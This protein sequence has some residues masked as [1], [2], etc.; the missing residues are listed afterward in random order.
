[1]R[2]RALKAPY[3]PGRRNVTHPQISGKSSKSK[4]VFFK[5]SEMKDLTPI[6]GPLGPQPRRW[7]QRA[8]RLGV[9]FG[10][11]AAIVAA[12]LFLFTRAF[13]SARLV[14][15]D[16][17]GNGSYRL[18]VYKYSG[19]AGYVELT[20]RQGKVFGQS[21]FPEGAYLDPEWSDDCLAV[22]VGTDTDRVKLGAARQ[23]G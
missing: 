20:D 3:D 8:S 7:R 15:T 2:N 1:M 22:T 10:V 18:S 6:D 14:H 11:L 12:T 5:A 16:V 17:C 19:G 13:D 21:D 9:L 4:G 23:G